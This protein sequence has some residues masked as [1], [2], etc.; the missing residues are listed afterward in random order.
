MHEIVDLE[1]AKS[2]PGARIVVA[3]LLASPW[4]DAAKGVFHLGGI[5]TKWVRFTRDPALGAWT[6]THNTPVVM[7]DDEPPRTSSADIVTLAS[8]LSRV[9]LVPSAAEDRARHFGWIHELAGEDGLGWCARVWMMDAGLTSE[10]KSGF[11][12]PVARFLAPKYGY[13]EGRLAHARARVED[14]LAVFERVLGEKEYVASDAPMAIDVY[15]ATFLAPLVGVSE[16][17]CPAMRPELRAA[18]D[19]IR[20]ELTVPSA[21]VAHRRRMYDRHLPMPIPL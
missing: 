9:A 16:E 13:A 19:T 10:G 6:H 14:I 2:A 3:A 18:F 1:T 15:L 17:E 5:D 4:T 7:H 11:T 8:R 20:G 21:L 12:V